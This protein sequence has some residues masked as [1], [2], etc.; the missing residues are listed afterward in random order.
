MVRMYRLT[1][2]ACSSSAVQFNP[3]PMVARGPRIVSN[4]PS[5]IAICRL[6]PCWR[7]MPWTCFM[8]STNVDAFLFWIISAVPNFMPWDMVMKMAIL[9]MNMTSGHVLVLGHDINGDCHHGGGH[10]CWCLSHGLTLQHTNIGTKLL[11]MYQMK[12]LVLG[13]PII[14]CMLLAV[15]WL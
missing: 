1:T 7:Y 6:K 2:G 13:H 9:L 4:S 11:S 3:I 15:Y 5:M 8:H 14:C 12:S 10:F